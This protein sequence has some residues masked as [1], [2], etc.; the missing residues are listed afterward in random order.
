MRKAAAAT[1]LSSHIGQEYDA[2]VT[3]INSKGTFVRLL[4]PPAEG[5]VVANEAGIDVGDKVRVRLTATEPSLGFID[6]VRISP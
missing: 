2:I 6:F 4:D 1:L 5:R 3:G